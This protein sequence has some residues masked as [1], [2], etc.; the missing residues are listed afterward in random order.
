MDTK[1]QVPAAEPAPT[2]KT[3]VSPWMEF[4]KTLAHLIL[5]TKDYIIG[6]DNEGDLDWETSDEFDGKPIKDSD[7]DGR[8]K[9][10]VTDLE[11]GQSSYPSKKVEENF[12]CRL[13]N[14]LGRVF[15]A[16]YVSAEKQLADAETYILRRKME[17]ARGWHLFTAA[18]TACSIAA[19]AFLCGWLLRD[20]WIPK[21]GFAAFFVVIA[22]AA[23]GLG[24]FL[25][26]VSRLGKLEVDPLA[27][28]THHR[29][30]SVCRILVGCV[31]ALP[32]SLS[33]YLGIVMPIFTATNRMAAGMVL[34]GFMA[35][36]LERYTP[37]L[38]IQM[39]K[40]GIK[41]ENRNES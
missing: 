4:K 24:A 35:G 22:M 23:G 34:V 27:D 5:E 30:E 26:I 32:A 28:K 20:F 17:E 29:A 25:S 1:P 8:L 2:P 6:L 21:I 11:H 15:I 33:V 12:K 3:N 38:L 14:A 36:M 19:L 31:A 10:R 16:D 9:T 41:E 18:I 40:T 37:N 39:S 7:A 13:G